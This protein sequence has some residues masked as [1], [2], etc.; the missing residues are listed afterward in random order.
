MRQR[1]AERVEFGDGSAAFDAEQ[2][3]VLAAHDV[4]ELGRWQKRALGDH[5]LARVHDVDQDAQGLIRLPQL[6]RVRIQHAEAELRFG[7]IDAPELMV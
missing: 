5:S 6:I 2:R 3:D 1:D 4:A 7:L